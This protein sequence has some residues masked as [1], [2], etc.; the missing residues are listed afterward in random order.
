M[1]IFDFVRWNV[2][3]IAATV[4]LVIVILG[5]VVWLSGRNVYIQYALGRTYHTGLGVTQD[6]TEAV[7]WYRKAAEQGFALAENNLG[8]MY[9]KGLG[10]P[11]DREKAILWFTRAAKQGNES[12][13]RELGKLGEIRTSDR[14]WLASCSPMFS[15][16][17]GSYRWLAKRTKIVA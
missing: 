11:Q 5:V 2:K 12:A 9:L 4:S 16:A 7:K 3:E 1:G 15:D 17:S 13:K 14:S 8:W 10:V 6:Y